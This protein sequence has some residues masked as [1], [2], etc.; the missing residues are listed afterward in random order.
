MGFKQWVT[1]EVGPGNF[2][3]LK[4]TGV[5]GATERLMSNEFVIPE[6]AEEHTRILVHKNNGISSN[7][8]YLDNKIG[9]PLQFYASYNRQFTTNFGSG[10]RF[11]T[12]ENST[13][14]RFAANQELLQAV[15][16]IIFSV[17]DSN[18]DVPADAYYDEINGE[19]LPYVSTQTAEPQTSEVKN[20]YVGGGSSTSYP[21]SGLFGEFIY[22]DHVLDPGIK[23]K[24][25]NYLNR[26]YGRVKACNMPDEADLPE[27]YKIYCNT[28]RGPLT[29]EECLADAKSANGVG[30]TCADYYHS[31]N[32]LYPLSISCLDSNQEFKFTGCFKNVSTEGDVAQDHPNDFPTRD[33]LAERI[34]SANNHLHLNAN[35]TNSIVPETDGVKTWT[36]ERSRMGAYTVMSRLRT[37]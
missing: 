4:F 29:V 18:T 5:S 13:P 7:P 3:Y 8:Y 19:R 23:E 30:F 24:I 15:P 36:S 25:T 26:K 31:N 34:I 1:L 6:G 33:N 11:H 28:K 17:F 16:S 14:D 22:F 37:S 32:E 27:G 20:L 10:Y 2:K 21:F 12:W 35:N 9:P